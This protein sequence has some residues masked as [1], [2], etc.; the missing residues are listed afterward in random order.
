[1]SQDRPDALV[2]SSR[3]MIKGLREQKYDRPLEDR[4]KT[5][6]KPLREQHGIETSL[7]M[8][9]PEAPLPAALDEAVYRATQEGLTNVLRHA[10]ATRVEVMVEAQ[11]CVSG[12]ELVFWMQD[13]G[14]GF[15][16]DTIAFSDSARKGTSEGGG[17][18][19]LGMRERTE[20]LG[21][22]LDLTSG[23]DGTR[24]VLRI[25]LSS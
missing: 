5:L 6:L 7:Q 8:Q 15:D 23:A 17:L 1:M 2:I 4:I 10:C 24:L 9:L 21:G 18:G 19:L 25:P 20:E 16:V 11:P 12:Q 13:N 3:L 14:S 22:L